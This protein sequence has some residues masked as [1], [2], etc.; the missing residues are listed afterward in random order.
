MS[1]T[2]TDSLR[3]CYFSLLAAM[4]VSALAN[5]VAAE[6]GSSGSPSGPLVIVG[7]GKVGP[8][9]ADRFVTLAGGVDAEIVVIPT[10]L[11]DPID[12]EA[13]RERFSKLF[14]FKRV[15][16]L[17][18]RDRAEADSAA[19]VAP[20][21]TAKGIWF[22]GGRHWRLIDSY[23]GTRTEQEL[24]ELRERGGVIGGSSAGATIQG[25]FLVRGAREGNHIMVAKD[26]PVG[27]GYL[28]DVAIDQ[29]ILPRGRA[30][31]LVP[32]VEANPGLLGLGIDEETAIVVEG[33][34]FEVVGRGV[35]AIHDGKDH[36][37]KKYYFLGPGERFDLRTRQRTEKPRD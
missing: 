1:K 4:V 11:E 36:D 12:L 21:Q 18:T 2:A 26:Y 28:Q 30:D 17:H 3:F 6:T 27:F 33:D 22:D 8:P 14:G 24:R 16:I 23:L 9:I 13:A 29:H 35:V 19:F 34:T 15:T 5:R 25:S 37:G 32:V 7:G 20:L 10:A 31:D